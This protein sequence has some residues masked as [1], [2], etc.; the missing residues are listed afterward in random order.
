MYNPNNP[1]LRPIGLMDPK[2]KPKVEDLFYNPNNPELMPEGMMDLDLY[3]K[4]FH[5][6][7]KL[8]GVPQGAPTS[9]SLAT[10][11]LR[12]LTA[13]LKNILFYADDVFYFPKDPDADHVK[14]LTDTYIGVH[15]QPSK[16]RLVRKNY[17]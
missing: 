6:Q 7:I 9:C 10:L 15:V 16:S 11:V 8:R 12:N 3:T 14:D 4:A 13:R 1:K 17:D 2:W 5:G